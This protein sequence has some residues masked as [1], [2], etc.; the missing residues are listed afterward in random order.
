MIP[1]WVLLGG[2]ILLL[3]ARSP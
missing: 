3:S 1:D 2:V